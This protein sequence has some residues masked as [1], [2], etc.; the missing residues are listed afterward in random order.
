[1]AVTRDEFEKGM[2]YQAY[3][4]QM[5]RNRERFEENERQVQIDPDD[6]AAFRRL[7]RPLNVLALA[8]DWC[9]DVIA[10]LPVLGKL[11]EASGKLNVRILLRDQHLD[12]MDRYLNRGEFRSIPTL[13][14]LDP[15][16]GEVGVFIERPESVT[17][18][19]A[20]KR[21]ALHA[22][23]PE[24]GEPGRPPNELPEDVREA[25]QA[26]MAGIRDELRSFSN[27][28]VIR[29]LRAIVEKAP[30]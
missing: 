14:F 23:H 6:L 5:T 10:N 16:F 20:E 4:A 22:A 13:V 27:K 18:A 7:S 15:D 29:G 17:K 11:A 25:Y 28:E 19:T 3:K 21:A 12:V 8:E 30:A 2:T 26:A 1:M 24:W 9:G